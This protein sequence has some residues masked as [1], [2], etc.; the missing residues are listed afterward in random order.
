MIL[1]SALKQQLINCSMVMMDVIVIR[2]DDGSFLADAQHD[3]NVGIYGCGET[4]DEAIDDLRAAI[5]EAREYCAELPASADIEF[6]I[7]RKTIAH[8]ECN[9][10]GYYFVYTNDKFPFGFFGEGKTKETA[11]EDFLALF[12]E[13]RIDHQ[14]R[15]GEDIDRT[16]EFVMDITAILNEVKKYSNFKALS[17]V[18]GIRKEV[19]AQY[20]SGK[21]IPKEEQHM[22]IVNGIHEIGNRCLAIE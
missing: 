11:I 8:I 19:L 4:I 14:K 15:T 17:E 22:R 12:E 13:M 18:T 2:E 3:Y 7:I 16:F 9:S 1:P 21:R 20:A 10:T 6:N 5:D